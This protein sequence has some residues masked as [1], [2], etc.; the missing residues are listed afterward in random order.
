MAFFLPMIITKAIEHASKPTPAPE[1]APASYQKPT[2]SIPYLFV[3]NEQRYSTHQW[4]DLLGSSPPDYQ[5][6]EVISLTWGKA[7]TSDLSHEFVQFIVEDTR[8]GSRTRC[9]SERLDR[10]D[11]DRIIV[12]RDYSTAYN[13][14]GQ[15]N[16]PMPLKSLIFHKK[17]PSIL[18]L[19]R[20]LSAI[21]ARA[22][23]YNIITM[24][25]WY[26]ESV[27]ESAKAAFGGELKKWPF[28]SFAYTM[29]IWQIHFW[30][31][32]EMEEQARK[33]KE[34][35]VNGLSYSVSPD[36]KKNVTPEEQV[37]RVKDLLE[38]EETS[39]GYEEAM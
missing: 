1:P 17:R 20:L 25:W 22:P 9:F 16:L 13:P 2:V 32:A 12:G 38:D 23:S 21:T 18:H 39:K 5:H 14:S 26:A 33:S 37:K 8:T 4:A 34:Q 19:A 29:V 7:L 6:Y 36:A 24:C 3:D 28:A 11:P 31:R 27:F 10:D 15:I 30:T 35:N